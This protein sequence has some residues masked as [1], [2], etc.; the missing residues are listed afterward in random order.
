MN[1]KYGNSFSIIEKLFIQSIIN[2]DNLQER[3]ELISSFLLTNE[4][5]GA[6][7]VVAFDRSP[8]N[9]SRRDFQTNQC[10]P[11]PVRGVEVLGEPCF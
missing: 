4:K 2:F 3:M 1:A 9:Y 10:R 7:N 8:F 11:H 5:R 6:L